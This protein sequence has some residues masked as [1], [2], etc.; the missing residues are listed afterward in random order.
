MRNRMLSLKKRDNIAKAVKPKV[1]R[2]PKGQFIHP[3]NAEDEVH[4]GMPEPTESIPEP[5][6]D[7]SSIK[8]SLS[9]SLLLDR[10]EIDS[11]SELLILGQFNFREFNSNAIKTMTRATV[12]ARVEF[13][14]IKG[15]ATLGA[16]GVSKVNERPL[17]IND[18][19]GWTK[20]ESFVES[21]M[22]EKKKDIM[23]TMALKFA[24]VCDDGNEESDEEKTAKPKGNKV[25]LHLLQN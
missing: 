22:R 6:A 18:E 4:E 15:S 21:F 20:A 2:V 7:V 8:F 12:K 14:F 11:D 3:N 23:L 25:H 9:W 1:K 10:V 17:T 13:E 5:L 16:K 19:E 24:K